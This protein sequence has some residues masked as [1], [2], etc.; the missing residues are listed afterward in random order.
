M[1]EV[2]LK[3]VR[4][5][6]ALALMVVA[7]FVLAFMRVPFPILLAA[8]LVAAPVTSI[9]IWRHRTRPEED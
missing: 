9:L 3:V 4:I 2:E 5:A 7:A 1:E 8:L 6:I